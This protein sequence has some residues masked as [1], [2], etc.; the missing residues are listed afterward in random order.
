MIVILSEAATLAIATEAPASADGRETGGVLLGHDTGDRI[1]VTVAGGPGPDADRRSDGFL[2]DLVH[3]QHL[4]DQAYDHDGSVWLGEWH[5][6]P[7]GPP[8]PSPIDVGTYERLLADS[9][10][11][12]ERLLSLIVTPC[13]IHGW[14][15]THVHGWL[16]TDEG[17]HAVTILGGGRSNT[18]AEEDT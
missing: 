11:G 7:T 13:V 2:R 14:S 6:H 12:F 18:G 3:A 1:S 5:T 4:G 15:E 8:S 9:D 10:L 16:V 17:T